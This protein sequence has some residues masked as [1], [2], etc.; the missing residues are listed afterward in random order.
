M[1][2]LNDI[3]DNEIRVIGGDGGGNV[4]KRIPWWVWVVA[5]IVAASVAVWL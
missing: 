2:K 1:T 3:N 5:G 4:K